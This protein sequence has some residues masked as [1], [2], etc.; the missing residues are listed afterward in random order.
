MGKVFRVSHIAKSIDE[1][2][3]FMRKNKDCGMIAEDNNGLIYIAEHYALTIPSSL[4]PD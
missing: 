3:E 4:L 2:N 1:A